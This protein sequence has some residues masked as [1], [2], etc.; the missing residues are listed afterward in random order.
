[1]SAATSPKS[2][3]ASRPPSLYD[4]QPFLRKMLFSW[5][6]PLLKLGRTK[7]LQ[8][9][10]LPALCNDD[11]SEFNLEFMEKFCKECTD[12]NTGEMKLHRALLWNFIKSVWWIQPQFA[13]ESGCKIGQAIALGKLID[14]FSQ[15]DP[16]VNPR[17]GY[18][19]AG[20][21]VACGA[22]I[23]QTHHHIYF[24]AWRRGMQ[25]RVA[26]VAA[27]YAKS[28]RLR[29]NVAGGDPNSTI[30]T[31]MVMNL[32]SN[33]VE[34][35]IMWSLFVSYLFWG[36]LEAIVVL[37][38]G[39][40]ILGPAFAAGYVLLALVIPIQFYLSKKF[41][42]YRSKIAALTDRRVNLVSQAVSGVRVMKM[43]G[44]ETSFEER[45]AAL[46]RI[47]MKEIQRAQRL[48]AT[49]EAIFFVCNVVISTVIFIIHT[50]T[51]GEF[52]SGVVFSTI[53]LMSLI[54]FTMGKFF[55]FAVM[56]SS[57]SNPSK[58]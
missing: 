32:A 24:Y 40:N 38:V 46:R 15:T 13:M 47:E 16:T 26:A 36:P 2:G 27:I 42:K 44:W 23:L 52:S 1:M 28:L 21:L 54:Q 8:E 7:T 49:N 17:D 4:N 9:E 18:I 33:D 31:G 53:S 20:V 25:Y 10:D 37:V 5:P 34:R 43:S 22:I 58:C 57:C 3:G 55:P 12:D 41:A 29:S 30:S 45:I 51:G 48:K 19:W 14:T 39:L 56:V 11:T 35:F 50:S 6:W